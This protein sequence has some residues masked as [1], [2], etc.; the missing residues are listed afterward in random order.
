MLVI[1]GV[2]K[3]NQRLAD[4]NHASL[5]EHCQPDVKPSQL[6]TLTLRV[7]CRLAENCKPC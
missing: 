6:S 5:P 7:Q 3:E 4:E 1:R 2:Y